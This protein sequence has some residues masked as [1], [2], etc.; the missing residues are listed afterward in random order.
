MESS[1]SGRKDR[2]DRAP[3][4]SQFTIPITGGVAGVAGQLAADRTLVGGGGPWP[5]R[6]SPIKKN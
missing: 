3:V 1:G 2:L 5:G 4:K 6:A